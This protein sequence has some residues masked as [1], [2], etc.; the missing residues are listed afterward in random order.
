MKVVLLVGN[1][2]G[3]RMDKKNET[4]RGKRR[5]SITYKNE[6]PSD[7]QE[8]P[9]S[10]VTEN[11]RNR[12]KSK[13]ATTPRR[14]RRR[15]ASAGV[16]D[17]LRY[18]YTDTGNAERLV[19]K[20]G[21]NI[22]Y[23]PDWKT[24]LI[25]DR[26]RWL[27][28][29]SREIQRGA[30]YAIREFYAQSASI[31]DNSDRQ[32]AES[33]ARLSESAAAIRAMLACAESEKGITVNATEL[34]LDPWLL[35]CQNGTL[36]LK[37]G[38]LRPHSQ[39]DLITKRC[40][41]DFD[42]KAPCPVFE[43]FIARILGGQAALVTYVQRV[44]GYALTGVVIEKACFCLFG[45]GNNGKTTLLELFRHILGD[46]SS[47]VMIDSLM[48]RRAQES[49]ASLADL[50]DLRGARFVTTSETEAGQRLAEG[51]L[52]Y[53]TG[54]SEVKTCRKYENPVTFAP[55]H[56]IFIDA[57]HR[58]VVRGS[59]TAIWTRLKLI[60]FIVSIPDDEIDKN[61]LNKLKAE[62]AGVLAWA[63]KGCLEW[64]K[65][66][67]AEP[68]EVRASVGTW[69]T[70]DDPHKEF[71]EDECEFDPSQSIP[72]SR[73][74]DAFR[75][76]AGENGLRHPS[77][78]RLYKELRLRGCTQVVERPIPNSKQVRSWKGVCVL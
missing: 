57:N 67:L 34:D 30:K 26:T 14:R 48:T 16:P 45:E 58:P 65:D 15:R 72:V 25:W 51:K 2:K 66:G 24:W 73:M 44:F 56:K 28:D 47:Q 22:R 3:R 19:A 76:W 49:N 40:S 33:H 62:V 1:R 17:L 63:V 10:S 42:A 11:P 35:N 46:Y 32:K 64:K 21:T 68:D 7:Q 9:V 78:E 59:D 20:F 31:P 55:T 41:V 23:C 74:W 75:T 4:R 69:R 18:P 27:P 54:M 12:K 50:A 5:A 70:E 43:G 39:A 77:K 71:F 38:K 8:H 53:L 61:L 36:D 52:K 6:D 29:R 60:P 37:T 13:T